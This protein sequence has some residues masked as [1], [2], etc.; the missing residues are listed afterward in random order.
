[1]RTRM[2][3]AGGA[4]ALLALG[5]GGVNRLR[6]TADGGVPRR[7][8]PSLTEYFAS[9]VAAADHAAALAART[10][11]PSTVVSPATFGPTPECSEAARKPSSCSVRSRL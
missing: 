6:R 9:R 3:I 10:R 2:L 7:P 4:V 11:A 1:M 8:D 5:W